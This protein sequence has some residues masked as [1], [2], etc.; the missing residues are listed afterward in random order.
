MLVEVEYFD[1]AS[2]ITAYTTRNVV[3]PD[4]NSYNGAYINWFGK[5]VIVEGLYL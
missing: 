1:G 3:F 2:N 5:K 4:K